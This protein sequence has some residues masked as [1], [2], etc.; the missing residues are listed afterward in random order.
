MLPIVFV[1]YVSFFTGTKETQIIQSLKI[2]AFFVLLSKTKVGTEIYF[3]RKLGV[4][5]WKVPQNYRE[6]QSGLNNAQYDCTNT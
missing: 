5:V 4:S 3:L 2:L 6:L 1:I